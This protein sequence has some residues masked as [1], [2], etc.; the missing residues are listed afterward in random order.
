MLGRRLGIA[1]VYQQ[2]VQSLV[3]SFLSLFELDA[4]HF[5]LGPVFNFSRINRVDTWQTQLRNLLDR[6]RGWFLRVFHGSELLVRNHQVERGADLIVHE[7]CNPFWSE[8]FQLELW[9]WRSIF[10]YRSDLAPVTSL[11]NLL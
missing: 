2:I 8:V 1:S 4:I 11:G 3:E 5:I 10:V 6:L 9:F 7:A